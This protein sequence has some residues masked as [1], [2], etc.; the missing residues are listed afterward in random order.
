VRPQES[1]QLL[2]GE[3]VVERPPPLVSFPNVELEAVLGAIFGRRDC[4]VYQCLAK[5]G[6]EEIRMSRWEPCLDDA[7]HNVRKTVCTV[8]AVSYLTRKAVSKCFGVDLPRTGQ[9]TIEQRLCADTEE[10]TFQEESCI[11]DFAKN[12]YELCFSR[13]SDGGV[14]VHLCVETHL[15]VETSWTRV[16]CSYARD[17]VERKARRKAEQWCEG[18]GQDAITAGQLFRTLLSRSCSSVKSV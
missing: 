10:V 15:W 16:P 2:Q 17:Y 8:P 5:L 3:P 12:R 9:M 18:V 1:G 6:F 7:G 4:I 11:Q 13:N 14:D